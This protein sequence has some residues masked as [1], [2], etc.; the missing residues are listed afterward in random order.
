MKILNYD[1]ASMGLSNTARTP[2]GGP[3]AVRQKLYRLSLPGASA[4]KSP[5][6]PRIQANRA[7]PAL[8]L[9]TNTQL[10]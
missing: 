7:F 8:S 1:R 3:V 10:W 6:V 9:P 5:T 4:L 2:Q